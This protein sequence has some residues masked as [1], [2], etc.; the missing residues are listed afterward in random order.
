[1]YEQVETI[2]FDRKDQFT[3]V[4]LLCKSDSLPRLMASLRI[5]N[6]FRF[7]DQARQWEEP[8]TREDFKEF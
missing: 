4:G 7:Q 1:M 5:V 8:G 2:V 6:D 3:Q